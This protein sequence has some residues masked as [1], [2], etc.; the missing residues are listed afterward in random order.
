MVIDVF[1]VMENGTWFYDPKLHALVL[2]LQDD[3]RAKTGQQD[4]V[5]TAPLNL[6]YVAHGSRMPDIPAED[7]HLYASADACFIGQNVSVLRVGGTRNGI[8]RRC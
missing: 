7:R 2:H 3:L 6:V 8:S 1:A 4:S 5:E